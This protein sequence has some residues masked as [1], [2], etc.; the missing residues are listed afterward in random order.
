MLLV[1]ERGQLK[2]RVAQGLL[3]SLATKYQE[4]SSFPFPSGLRLEFLQTP[5]QVLQYVQQFVKSG[6]AEALHSGSARYPGSDVRALVHLHSV[7]SEL[8]IVELEARASRDI[9]LVQG[10]LK[11][12]SAWAEAP[13]PNSWAER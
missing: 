10:F 1:G 3:K 12:H 9:A 7:A 11:R 6:G 4:E 13:A 5:G 8:G 2:W